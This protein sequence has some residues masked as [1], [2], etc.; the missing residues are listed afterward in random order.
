MTSSLHCSLH[1]GLQTIVSRHLSVS[2]PFLKHKTI[3][4]S[5]SL[6]CHSCNLPKHLPT[7]FCTWL[8]SFHPII[9]AAFSVDVDYSFNTLPLKLLIPHISTGI[10]F[11][12]TF[13][14]QS[15]TIQFFTKEFHMILRSLFGTS[16]S[17]MR[18]HTYPTFV[19][20]HLAT[21]VMC[22]WSTLIPSSFSDLDLCCLIFPKE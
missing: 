2:L 18:T 16:Y 9:L 20:F 4:Y 11:H 8:G 10:Y 6:H 12:T 7:L 14:T 13:K 21:T 5:I 19:S 1:C 15:Y 22:S 3:T 17:T